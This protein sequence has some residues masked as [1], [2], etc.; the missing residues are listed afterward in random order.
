MNS[1]LPI[2]DPFQSAHSDAL[3]QLIR[4]T[5][6]AQGGWIDFARYMA[7]AL[8]APG[9]AITAPVRRNSAPR[10]ILSPHPK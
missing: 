8:Y 3:L 7:L 9:S 4:Q 10:A 2:P 1:P 5:I 6:G